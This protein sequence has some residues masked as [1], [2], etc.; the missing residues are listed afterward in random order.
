MVMLE[1]CTT[2]QVIS[3]PEFIQIAQVLN[4]ST[5]DT[6]V[7][8]LTIYHDVDNGPCDLAHAWDN[9]CDAECCG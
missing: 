6:I 2:H 5:P 3:Y 1:M 9:K 8:A 7:P 4:V